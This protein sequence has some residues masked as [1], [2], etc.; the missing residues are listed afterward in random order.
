MPALDKPA[1][2]LPEDLSEQL[3]HVKT[4]VERAAL[5]LP[6]QGPI[7]IFVY[8]NPL[9]AHED[10]PF[11]KAV[12]LAYQQYHCQPYYSEDK[13]REWLENGRIRREDLAELL[14]EDLG[15]R[16]DDLIDSL[17]TRYQL[18]LAMLERHL[19][20]GTDSE[21][22]WLIEETGGLEKFCPDAP[23]EYRQRLIDDTRAW[24][25]RLLSSPDES[26][27][28]RFTE[29]TRDLLKSAGA[30]ALQRWSDAEWESLCLQ[31]IWRLCHQGAHGV[32]RV[33]TDDEMGMEEVSVRHRDLL[34]R[35]TGMDIDEAVNEVLIRYCAAYV[36]QGYASWKLPVRENGFYSGFLTLYLSARPPGWLRLL[37]KEVKHVRDGRL[38]A[39]ESIFDSLRRLGVSA[40]ETEDYLTQTMMSLR[41]W[42]GMIW[43]LE[44]RA[45]WAP[46]PAPKGTLIEFVAVKLILERTAL[47]YYSRR[48]LHE[49]IDL[50]ELRHRLRQTK[51]RTPRVHVDQRAYQLFQLAQYRGWTPSELYGLKKSQWAHLIASCEEF[52]S[53]ER[54]R[55][56]QMA[57]E[58][59][60]YVK[61]LDAI[62]AH[63]RKYFG[64]Q[65]KKLSFQMVTC[66][67]D[68]EESF[69]RHTEE[70]CPNCQTFGSAGFFGV[71]MYYQGIDEAFFKPLCPVVV[72]PRQYVKEVSAYSLM[73][74]SLQRQQ[75]RRRLGA[76]SRHWHFQS[77]T[78]AGGILTALLGPLTSVPV[79]LEILFPHAASKFQQTF[80]TLIQ[81]P[82]VTELVLTRN[83]EECGPEEGHLGF[84]FLEMSQSVERILTEIGL[85]KN[86]ARIVL[87][88]GHGSSSLNNP[89]QAAYNCGAC[90]GGRGGPNA[91]SLTRMANLPQVR[92]LL[93][94]RGLQIPDETIFIGGYHNT[95]N[96]EVQYYDLDLIPVTHRPD[97]E[98]ARNCL[99]EARAR[100]AAERTRRFET[101]PLDL[102]P[103]QALKEVERR[104]ADLSQARP[105]FIHPTNA[106][107]VVGRRSRTRGLFLDRRCFLNDYDPHQDDE[108]GSILARILSAAFP[109]CG[110]INLLYYFSTIDVANYGCG[111]KL[112]HNVVSLLGVMEG[113]LSD[114]RPGLAQQMVEIHES[115]RMIFVIETTVEKITRI[116]NNSP[117][118]KRMVENSWCFLAILDP[119]SP[120]LVLYEKGKFVPYE[121]HNLQIKEMQNSRQC[122]EGRR[123]P[124]D[125]AFVKDG[126]AGLEDP[127]TQVKP[128]VESR[129]FS[130]TTMAGFEIDTRR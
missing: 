127:D 87:I 85:T 92:E 69:R 20:Q 125:I 65:R 2:K 113:A 38:T 122:Y 118:I 81:P 50:T 29:M 126:L 114:L 77:R 61:A 115:M 104:S 19:H 117:A 53:V 43:Q 98:H 109:V 7:S 89:H 93:R 25:T 108:N 72:T 52:P 76:A 22:R 47:K 54:R 24:I 60:Y 6:S 105:E 36:D 46:N 67:D 10:L 26:R 15:D 5:R 82:Q 73:I 100:N 49:S 101:V 96:D 79:I 95:C 71:P 68:R 124:V 57:Y 27:E 119:D 107:T 21:I 16:A 17:G 35:A 18:Y 123:G 56:Y 103:Q 30:N 91:R 130:S 120:E 55:L 83:E 94:A 39:L 121:P 44:T 12:K 8:E 45:S 80:G 90:S 59:R 63:G 75:A 86:F 102:T 13:Y 112:P 11:D 40:R 128:M 84:T 34:Y 62:I 116:M 99:E 74:S 1:M 51:S 66:I 64:K 37:P 110:G 42:A 70:V 33:N 106:M 78:F 3:N 28:N 58:R 23:V 9:Q 88:V 4:C 48:L 129:S 111:S 41:G 31:L 14:L 32:P 97:F